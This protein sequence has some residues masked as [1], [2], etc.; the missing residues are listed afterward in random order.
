MT[1][2]LPVDTDRITRGAEPSLAAAPDGTVWVSAPSIPVDLLGFASKVTGERSQAQVWLSTDHGRTFTRTGTALLG[3]KGDYSGGGDSDIAVDAGGRVYMADLGGGVPVIMSSDHGKTWD[4]TPNATQS[5]STDREWVV[6]GKP[7]EA[8]LLFANFTQEGYSY[9]EST[10][11]EDGGKTWHWPTTKVAQMS[12]PESYHGPPSF[13]AQ[14][15]LLY[16][17]LSLR[18]GMAVGV[19]NDS[20]L[21]WDVQ[22]VASG[23]SE[24]PGFLLPSSAVDRAGNAYVAWAEPYAFGYQVWLSW[25]PPGGKAWSKP[26]LVSAADTN[27]IMPTVVA[28]DD[29][30]V[31]VAYYASGDAG[32]PDSLEAAGDTWYLHV[33]HILDVRA[34][35]PE[36]HVDAA[37]Q[38]P[39][40]RGS[41]CSRGG[42]CAP[43]SGATGPTDRSLGDF[44]KATLLPDGSLAIA[45]DHDDPTPGTLADTAA[46]V[47]QSGGDSLLAR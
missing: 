35:L 6:G 11:T 13:D 15:R 3:A 36:F 23:L 26:L 16:A 21:T 39:V 19:S 5:G 43:F 32:N 17:P 33:A 28:G 8:F 25:A 27:A 29:S 34:A 40:H 42:I 46:V 10:F 30:R 31:A 2:A 44:F 38:D 20:G 18:H 45:Y 4:V 37:V 1:F 9:L 47:V 24:R 22:T 14:R 12:F 41:V 7:G